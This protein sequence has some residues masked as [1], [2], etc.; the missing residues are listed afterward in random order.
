MSPAS[1]KARPNPFYVLLMVVSTLFVVTSMGYLVGPFV[2]RQA[3]D[4]PGAGPGPGSRALAAWF[5]R[6]GVVA[7]G[8]EFVAMFLLA[9]LAMATDRHFSTP[10]ARRGD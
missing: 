9:L 7:L 4:N 5:E 3:V 6:R 8:I 10:D 1:T 2:E